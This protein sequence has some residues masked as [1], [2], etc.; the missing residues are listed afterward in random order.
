MRKFNLVLGAP[1]IPC[2]LAAVVCGLIPGILCESGEIS[3]CRDALKG[4][5]SDLEIT[6]KINLGQLSAAGKCFRA[7]SSDLNFRYNRLFSLFGI[8][9]KLNR[10]GDNC[11]CYGFLTTYNCAVFCIEYKMSALSL[12]LDKLRGLFVSRQRRAGQ[13]C[14]YHAQNQHKRQ[15]SCFH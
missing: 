1:L 14:E 2:Q 11:R 13:K 7:D 8:A 15:Y 4:I 5:S 10:C 6:L 12:K 9:F 3:R